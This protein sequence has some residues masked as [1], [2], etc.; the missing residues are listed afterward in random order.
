MIL[1]SSGVPLNG[2]RRNDDYSSGLKNTVLGIAGKYD[3]VAATEV[4][5][6]I[7]LTDRMRGS[8]YR[9]P[10]FRRA[11]DTLPDDCTRRGW[12]IE[13]N[14]DEMLRQIG[15]RER[16][17]RGHKLARIRGGAGLIL[18]LRDGSSLNTPTSTTTGIEAVHVAGAGMLRAAPGSPLEVDPTH[19]DFGRPLFY[20][21]R[22]ARGT[23]DVLVVH[24]DRVVWLEG[25]PVDP[26]DDLVAEQRGLSVIDHVWESVRNYLVAIHGVASTV[27]EFH[28]TV[29]GIADLADLLVAGPGP[30]GKTG[31]EALTER[32]EAMA[33]ARSL[34]KTYL[35][36]ADRESIERL[37]APVRGLEGLVYAL[38]QDVAM[39]LKMPVTKVW[40]QAPAGLSTDDESGRHNWNNEVHT[41]Q[42]SYYEP[43]I[44]RVVDMVFPGREYEIEF[45]PLSEPTDTERGEARSKQAEE[46]ERYIRLNVLSAKEVR[47]SRFGGPEYSHR[48]VLIPG[49]EPQESE[50][51]EPPPTETTLDA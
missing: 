5:V 23:S 11:V 24:R 50:V 12:V 9:V 46:D 18:V 25:L 42:E 49:E 35:K 48:T 41:V 30:G 3:R 39:A 28:Y 2:I 15:L 44:R 47:E 27:A 29:L 10:L 45:L 40:G 43:A 26:E 13:R 37:G 31:E 17:N 1:D 34:L 51:V 38:M 6:P 20:E 4:G 36:D 21:W 22:I 19:R 32:F 16:L 7:R 8:L 33:E 14:I